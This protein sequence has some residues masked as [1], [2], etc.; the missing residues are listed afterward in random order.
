MRQARVRVEKTIS[1][2]HL[3]LNRLAVFLDNLQFRILFQ[4]ITDFLELDR[5]PQDVSANMTIQHRE[6]NGE[7][8]MPRLIDLLSGGFDQPA[9]FAMNDRALGPVTRR[10]IVTRE[11]TSLI[12]CK[13]SS[14]QPP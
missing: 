7:S 11:S 3:D 12:F 9:H 4:N 10:T 8:F 1:F 6:W 13:S 5:P 2:L 14:A